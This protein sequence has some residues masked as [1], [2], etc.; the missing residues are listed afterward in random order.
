MCHLKNSA[1]SQ[2]LIETGFRLFKQHGFKATGIDLITKESSISKAT[3]YK[4]FKNKEFL[5]LAIL[6]QR[7]E[8][9]MKDAK[10]A[11]QNQLSSSEPV[12]GIFDA[13]HERFQQPD[14]YGCLFI[15]AGTEYNQ[16]DS[17]IYKFITQVKTDLKQLLI[18]YLICETRNKTQA[19]EKANCLMILIDG[20]IINA[21]LCQNKDAALKA[22]RI[23]ASL[24]KDVTEQIH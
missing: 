19:E 8:L 7:H 15:R 24:L 14:F 20:T 1:K 18:K 21:Q 22:K 11:I 6:K 2:L 5:I 13:F 4:Y 3:L 17:A 23:A 16:K 12:L 10:K 9:N